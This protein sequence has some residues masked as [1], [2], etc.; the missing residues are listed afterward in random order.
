V[1]SEV[2][3][4]H[5]ASDFIYNMF[6][7]TTQEANVVPRCANFAKCLWHLYGCPMEQG[8]PFSSCCLFYLFFF[9]A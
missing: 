3:D 6:V 1:V 2:V 7:V 5:Q 9:L 8:W 4:G